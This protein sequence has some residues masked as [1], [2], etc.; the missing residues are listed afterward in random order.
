MCPSIGESGDSAPEAV[1]SEHLR[2]GEPAHEKGS[3]GVVGGVG[4]GVGSVDWS[5]LAA[6]RLPPAPPLAPPGSEKRSR[7]R[8][9][10]GKERAVEK[11][12]GKPAGGPPA[13]ER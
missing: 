3:R 12:G 11:S 6:C 8:E 7:A 2:L 1:L 13:H 9:S 10:L 5:T 4:S